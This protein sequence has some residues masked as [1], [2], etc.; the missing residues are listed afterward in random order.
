[1]GGDEE[2]GGGG[3]GGINLVIIQLLIYIFCFHHLLS[4]STENLKLIS[5][6]I[7]HFKT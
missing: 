2:S 5:I 4:I 3:G 6:K 7:F 1:M